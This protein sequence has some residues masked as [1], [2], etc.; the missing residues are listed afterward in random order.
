VGLLERVAPN[1]PGPGRRF[2]AGSVLFGELHRQDARG[3]HRIGSV[4]GMH[5][6]VA[7]V[8]DPMALNRASF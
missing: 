2:A 5:G 1:P 4:V 6:H 8:V 7:V 3:D